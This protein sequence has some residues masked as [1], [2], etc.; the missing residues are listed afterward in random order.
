MVVFK[1]REATIKMSASAITID[2]SGPI[3]ADFTGAADLQVKNIT[4]TAP[5]GAL[6]ILTFLGETSGFQ[7]AAIEQKAYTMASVSGTLVLDGDE[8]VIINIMGGATGDA[9]TGGYTRYQ[10]GES[11]SGDARSVVSAFLLNVDNTSEEASFVLNNCI[12]NIKEIKPTDS[13]GHFEID[14]E[15]SCLPKDFYIEFKD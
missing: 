10:I 15:G 2:A 9:I 13:D 1:T 12:F 11:T 8:Q 4:V 5:E 6:E 3:D 7:N 14:F